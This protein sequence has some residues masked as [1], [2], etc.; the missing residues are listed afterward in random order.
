MGITI[1]QLRNRKVIDAAGVI[2]GDVDD[3]YLDAETLH[4]DRLCIKLRRDLNDDLGV[5]KHTFTRTTIEIPAAAVQSVGDTV[6]L[7][8]RAQNLQLL[9]QPS[10]DT[11]DSGRDVH[12]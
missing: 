9:D 10:R 8:V 3:V 5:E 1:E 11:G 12:H 2:L 4:A 7:R 6:I